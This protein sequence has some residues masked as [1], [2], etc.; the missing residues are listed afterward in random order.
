MGRLGGVPGRGE[1]KAPDGKVAILSVSPR[2]QK[3]DICHR[4]S[5]TMWSVHKALTW[6]LLFSC[7]A[8]HLVKESPL[9]VSFFLGRPHALRIP[10]FL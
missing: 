8:E 6:R 4:A 9:P 3:I 1:S 10:H 5:G 7:P 2:R